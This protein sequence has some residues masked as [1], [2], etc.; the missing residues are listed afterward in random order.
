MNIIQIERAVRQVR[1]QIC[2]LED[3]TRALSAY[4]EKQESGLRNLQAALKMADV[5]EGINLRTVDAW[6]AERLEA[7]RQ[8][9]KQWGAFMAVWIQH[10]DAKS[11]ASVAKREEKQMFRALKKAAKSVGMLM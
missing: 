5:P 11:R 1:R 4:H 6:V 3:L 7:Y 10:Q 2:A 9:E 8:D